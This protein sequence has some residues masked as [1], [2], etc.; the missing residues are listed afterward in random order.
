MMD[1][2]DVWGE[3]MSCDWYL[4]WDNKKVCGMKV[5]V[6]TSFIRRPVYNMTFHR[7]TEQKIILS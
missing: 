6:L 7:L 5:N 1:A 3:D 2:S 4:F